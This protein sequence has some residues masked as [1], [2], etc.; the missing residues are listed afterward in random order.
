MGRLTT[1][2]QAFVDERAYRAVTVAL[3]PAATA[4]DN[5]AKGVPAIAAVVCR[6]ERLL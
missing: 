4:P 3:P 6:E 2:P 1:K 5:L